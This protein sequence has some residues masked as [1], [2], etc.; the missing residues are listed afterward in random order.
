MLVAHLHTFS[1]R[2]YNGL[3]DYLNGNIIIVYLDQHR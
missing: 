3:L 1:R 2:F